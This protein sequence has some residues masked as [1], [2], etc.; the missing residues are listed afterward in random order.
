MSGFHVRFN[1][2][3]RPTYTQVER[4]LRQGQQHDTDPIRA[5]RLPLKPK[6]G[7]HCYIYQPSSGRGVT[8]AHFLRITGSLQGQ[9]LHLPPS[10][11]PPPPPQTSPLRTKSTHPQPRPSTKPSSHSGS[12]PSTRLDP[13]PTARPASSPQPFSSRDHT[14]SGSR[15]LF[16]GRREWR[17]WRGRRGMRR[18]RG[19]GVSW[20]I[21]TGLPAGRSAESVGSLGTQVS[22]GTVK[23]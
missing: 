21:L 7:Q 2:E 6:P 19:M 16:A 17:I 9:R 5:P 12:G 22:G 11:P 20:V 23:N 10:C 4:F 1:K 3:K 18:G 15:W 8:T 13:P 14:A